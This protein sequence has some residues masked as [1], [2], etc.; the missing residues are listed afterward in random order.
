MKKFKQGKKFHDF[1]F[2]FLFVGKLV[3]Y[4]YD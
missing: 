4:V 3:S 1:N 2:F